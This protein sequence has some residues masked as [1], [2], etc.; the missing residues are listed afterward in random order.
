MK[1]IVSLILTIFIMAAS[2]FTTYAIG[3]DKSA[4]SLICLDR[5][6]NFLSK[7]EY[8]Y[9]T[10]GSEHVALL[11][12]DGSLWMA[13][14]NKE[15]ELGIGEIRNSYNAPIKVMEDV[16]A[17]R[18]INAKNADAKILVTE[19]PAEYIML[20]KTKPVDIELLTIEEAVLK[21]L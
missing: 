20:S 1:K 10:G 21:C 7:A 16:A 15:G 5:E 9:I 19:C 11:R 18:W 13:G 6:Y 12:P 17:N 3:P 4:K 2:T 14:S 8:S